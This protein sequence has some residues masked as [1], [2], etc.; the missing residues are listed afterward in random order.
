[1]WIIIKLISNI[2]QCKPDS[3]KMEALQFYWNSYLLNYFYLVMIIML[4]IIWVQ[5]LKLLRVRYDCSL[6]IFMLINSKIRKNNI[7]YIMIHFIFS[8]LAIN[9]VSDVANINNHMLLSLLSWLS[10][11]MWLIII[12]IKYP[13]VF[14]LSFFSQID[15]QNTSTIT[16]L[17]LIKLIL[18]TALFFVTNNSISIV[19]FSLSVIV[20]AFIAVHFMFI[21][22]DSFLFQ[23]YNRKNNGIKYRWVSFYQLHTIFIFTKFKFYCS[24]WV[25]PVYAI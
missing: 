19:F 12:L 16:Y 8:F 11:L 25:K 22:K 15:S 21:S 4:M 24:H 1:M 7:A 5:I 17:T 23:V 13:E 10:I 6:K 9:L 20:H 3:D 14:S 2:D 18:H